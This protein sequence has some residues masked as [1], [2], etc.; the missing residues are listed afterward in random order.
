MDFFTVLITGP[1]FFPLIGG[2]PHA[3]VTTAERLSISN[4]PDQLEV[5]PSKKILGFI[6][7]SSLSN[8]H[9]TNVQ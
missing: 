7:V 4:Y 5:G 9:F 6:L 1:I 2:S 3:R 8:Q